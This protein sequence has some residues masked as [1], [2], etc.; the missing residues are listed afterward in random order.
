MKNWKT[1]VGGILLG[2]GLPLS[3]A[4]TG[5]YKVIGAVLASASAVLLGVSAADHKAP[6]EDA[7]TS[8]P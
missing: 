5:I 3:T 7:P 1:T 8:K 6:S 2:I 4:G